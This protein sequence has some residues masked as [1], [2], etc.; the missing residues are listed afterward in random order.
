MGYGGSRSDA[1]EQ[2]DAPQHIASFG[3]RVERQ[4]EVLDIDQNYFSG[5]RRIGLTILEAFAKGSDSLH[6]PTDSATHA[7]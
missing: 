4:I 1:A 5:E 2:S 7:R 3:V 6:S